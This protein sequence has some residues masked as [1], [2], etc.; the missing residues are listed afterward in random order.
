MLDLS[1]ACATFPVLQTER[2]TLR[3]ITVDDADA[4]FTIMRDPQ[5]MLYYGM[6]MRSR[7]DAV[8]RANAIRDAF[9]ERNGVYWAIIDQASGDLVGSG[10]FWQIAKPHFRAN[11]AYELAPAWWN[12]GIM[13]EA[14]GAMLTFGFETLGLHSIEAETH[15]DNIGSRR[16]LE[17][18]GFVQEGYFREKYFDTGR[19]CFIDTAVFS[20]LDADWEKNAKSI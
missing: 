5:V 9:Q 7:E 11:I 19:D 6:P 8:K 18:L 16:V 17:K 12:R 15:P 4:I 10:G 13:T 2:L 14:A 3:E 20:L 1:T